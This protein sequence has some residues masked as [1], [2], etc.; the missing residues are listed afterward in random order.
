LFGH[1]SDKVDGV[2]SITD[3]VSRLDID[4]EKHPKPEPTTQNQSAAGVIE[5]KCGMPLCICEAPAA[6]TDPVPMQVWF[7]YNDFRSFC[8][9]WR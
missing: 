2:D 1:R 6:K 5:C 4:T 8:H 9:K 7:F 3:K